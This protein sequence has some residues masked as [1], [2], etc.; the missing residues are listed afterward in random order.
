MKETKEGD[1]E[2]SGG[3]GRERKNIEIKR[4]K[5]KKNK[6]KVVLEKYF[7]IFPLVMSHI[8]LSAD[9]LK[10]FYNL[11]V[12]LTQLSHTKEQTVWNNLAL[13]L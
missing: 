13:T 2:G 10:I 4:I 12:S 9:Y 3:K 6:K 11:S 7:V 8:K 1:I 5:Y